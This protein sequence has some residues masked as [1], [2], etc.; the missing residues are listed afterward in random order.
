MDILGF[1]IE[2]GEALIIAGGAI[3][4]VFAIKKLVKEVEE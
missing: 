2:L 1:F 4:F 3:L